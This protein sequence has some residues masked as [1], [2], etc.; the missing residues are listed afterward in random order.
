MLWFTSDLHLCHD[1]EFVYK[2]RGC[3]SIS[4][5]EEKIIENWNNKVSDDDTVY[6]LGDLALGED[7]DRIYDILSKLKGNKILYRGN[8][9]TDRKLEFYKEHEDV[10]KL[11]RVEHADDPIKYKKYRFLPIHYPCL[12][13]NLE[14]YPTETLINLFGHTHS[15]DLF[16]N[17]IPYMYN[18]A[19]DAH[20]CSP[21]SA[22]EII[23]DIKSKVKE[24]LKF[25]V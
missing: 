5:E 22:E 18:V 7:F 3:E 17:D 20:D 2:P 12:C 9:D 23:E 25:L 15:K 1:R 10:F 24:C 19:C 6:I 4:A 21:V 11:K 14:A 13:F 16:Y 8:H